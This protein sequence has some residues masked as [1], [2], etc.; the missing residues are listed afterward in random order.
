MLYLVHG[1][2]ALRRTE[3]LSEVRRSVSPD[4]G[5]ADLNTVRLD[6]KVLTAEELEA[7][8]GAAPFLADR[9]LVIVEGLASRL[10]RKDEE[11]KPPRALREG[12]EKRLAAYFTNLPEW[13][14]LVLVETRSISALN[15][16][17]VAL[18][19]AGGKEVR[20][21]LPKPNSPELRNWT[22][23][24]ARARGAQ[25]EPTALE[26]LLAYTGNNSLLLE[27]ELSKLAA[28]ADGRAISA[29]DVRQ[30]VTYSRE[31]IVFD[32]TDALG[33][34]DLRMALGKLHELLD[35]DEAPIYLLTMVSRQVN[36]LLRA[37]ELLDAG[38]SPGNLA[39]ELGVHRFVGQK[40]G[41]QARNFSLGRLRT[42]HDELVAM[43]AAIKTGKMEPEAA[44][45]LFTAAVTR[46]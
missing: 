37:R 40:L 46:R 20:L 26:E 22:V 38:T 44:L 27:Q 39:T 8:C 15:G 35:A 30:L 31:A 28:F 42:L 16:F 13:T 4:A 24:R 7:A 36:Q 23:E 21:A 18:V 10:E 3:W 9:R 33:R 25:L 43:D 34:R 6:A 11:R 29:D 45:D 14:D 5:M 1:E 41:E 32:F 19:A 17:A 2:D 12:D